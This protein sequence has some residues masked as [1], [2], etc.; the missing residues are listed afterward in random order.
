MQ[1]PTLITIVIIE[2]KS[3]RTFQKVMNPRVPTFTVM[4]LSE[5]QNDANLFGANNNEIMITAK[6]AIAIV[7]SVLGSIA[8]YCSANCKLMIV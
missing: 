3:N 1:K 5:T 2:T 8:L 7:D 6:L 4:I